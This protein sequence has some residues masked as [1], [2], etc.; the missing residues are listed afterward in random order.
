MCTKILYQYYDDQISGVLRRGRQHADEKF[1]Q[2]FRRETANPTHRWEDNIRTGLHETA[3][4]RM[5]LV[6]GPL[7]GSC[8]D[9]N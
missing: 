5:A 6:R 3:S 9:G 7:V 1:L 2:N 8:E 4:V